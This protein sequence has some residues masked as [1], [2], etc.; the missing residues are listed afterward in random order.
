MPGSAPWPSS[1]NSCVH[2]APEAGSPGHSFPVDRFAQY[3]QEVAAP[4]LVYFGFGKPVCQH[5][6]RQV[7]ELRDVRNHRHDGSQAVEIAADSHVVDAY[8]VGNITD[9]LHQAV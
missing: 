5:T 9:V 3:T 8:Q 7:H 2:R 1:T 4:D 6:T